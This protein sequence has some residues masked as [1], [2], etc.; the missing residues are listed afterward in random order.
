MHLEGPRW[1]L[2][3]VDE[4]CSRARG[5]EE[6]G[7]CCAQHIRGHAPRDA[8]AAAA[9]PLRA[10]GWRSV[11]KCAGHEPRIGER[12]RCARSLQPGCCGCP[13]CY[14]LVN[15]RLR[16][17]LCSPAALQINQGRPNTC[18]A[19]WLAFRVQRFSWAC[20]QTRTEDRRRQGRVGDTHS[21]GRQH[22]S[23]TS[24]ASKS[25][26]LDSPAMNPKCAAAT[27]TSS[28][29]SAWASR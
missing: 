15:S 5:A 13:L 25:V 6:R 26:L 1:R 8:R 17:I 27:R 20:C 29:S 14:A 7:G 19:G 23:D 22:F 24:N 9:A 21:G 11:G 10:R 18:D 3:P 28:P 12:P 2:G 4:A 16:S